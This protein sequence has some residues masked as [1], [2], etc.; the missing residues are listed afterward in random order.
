MISVI[1]SHLKNLTHG[2]VHNKYNELSTKITKQFQRTISFL[3]NLKTLVTGHR[4]C[5][6][7][8]RYTYHLDA[9][10]L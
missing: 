3:M 5:K 4:I 8:S 9:R 10:F 7:K 2:R 6:S 1:P